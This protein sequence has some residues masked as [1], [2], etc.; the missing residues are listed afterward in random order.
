MHNMKCLCGSGLLLTFGSFSVNIT[1]GKHKNIVASFWK[2]TQISLIYWDFVL[3]VFRVALRQWQTHLER[4]YG[5]FCPPHATLQ[6]MTVRRPNCVAAGHEIAGLV[7]TAKLLLGHTLS[8][9]N[10]SRTRT[11]IVFDKWVTNRERDYQWQ[12]AGPVPARS[13]EWVCGRSLLGIV[14]SNPAW[15]MEVCLF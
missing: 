11:P 1:K 5:S 8:Q 12:W 4:I 3:R 15:G 14:G 6:A 13:K 2:C 10:L 9:L 7:F